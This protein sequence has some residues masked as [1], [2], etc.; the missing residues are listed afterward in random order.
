MFQPRG[1]SGGSAPLAASVTSYWDVEVNLWVM[2]IG[3]NVA[4][5]HPLDLKELL[6]AQRKPFNLRVQ[7]YVLFKKPFPIQSTFIVYNVPDDYASTTPNSISLF[8]AQ[9]L[10]LGKI[11]DRDILMAQAG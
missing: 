6:V 8:R 1:R 9:G 11:D 4:G 10:D 5:V 2:T 7:L 3:L